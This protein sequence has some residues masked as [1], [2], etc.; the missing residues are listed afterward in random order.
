MMLSNSVNAKILSSKR[1]P[2]SWLQSIATCTDAEYYQSLLAKQQKRFRKEILTGFRN[3]CSDI[4]IE[5][6]IEMG[7]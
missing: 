6:K 5:Q 2:P 3:K 1:C 7:S 4:V